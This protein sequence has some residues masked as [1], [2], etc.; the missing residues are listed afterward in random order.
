MELTIPTD[1]WQAKGREL[2]DT[3]KQR[4]L[5]AGLFK[6]ELTIWFA[7]EPPKGGASEQNKG[8]IQ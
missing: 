3:D 5:D 7:D 6:Q 4:M 1:E 2:L 8:H